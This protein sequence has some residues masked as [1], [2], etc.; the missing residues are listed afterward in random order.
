MR[1]DAKSSRSD[2]V[3]KWRLVR[4]MNAQYAV[5][6]YDSRIQNTSNSRDWFTD[7]NRTNIGNL[8]FLSLS[9]ND[10]YI[11]F[12]T[13]SVKVFPTLADYVRVW[14]D[15]SVL[16]WSSPDLPLMLGYLA[17]YHRRHLYSSLLV[18]GSPGAWC[19]GT[20]RQASTIAFCRVRAARGSSGTRARDKWC[21]DETVWIEFITRFQRSNAE[22][23]QQLTHFCAN[24]FS[25][26]TK[27]V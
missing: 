23:M 19:A 11:L 9:R 27:M 18:A 7:A 24:I 12:F 8:T 14:F 21:I 22:Q 25:V 20:G 16:T 26:T 10:K 5:H 17:V 13:T 1:E 4:C 6:V 15:C 2:S 3:S